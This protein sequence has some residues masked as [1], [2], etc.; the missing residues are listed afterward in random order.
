MKCK[1]IYCVLSIL[2]LISCSSDKPTL[3]NKPTPK[4][5][6]K[7]PVYAVIYYEVIN[8]GECNND[9]TGSLNDAEYYLTVESSLKPTEKQIIP[10][11]NGG[12]LKKDRGYLVTPFKHTGKSETLLINLLDEDNTD[13]KIVNI[14]KSAEKIGGTLLLKDNRIYLFKTILEYFTKK[15]WDETLNENILNFE[16]FEPCGSIKYDVPSIATP[17]EKQA[18]FMEI[19]DNG[20]L[21]MK[22]KVY[23]N[24]LN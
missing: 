23:Y 4:P 15:P 13:P 11:N 5:V 24:E 2:F 18:A 14:I 3:T 22:I 6:E 8:R 12:N 9:L 7:P 21:K 19:R 1:Y 16:G 17:S 10:I 20:W